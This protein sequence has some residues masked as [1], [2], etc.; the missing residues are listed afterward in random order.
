MK[1]IIEKIQKLKKEKNAIILAHIYQLPEIQDIA[2]FV[3]DSLDLSHKAAKTDADIIVFC[4]VHFMAETAAILSP[5]KKIL[6]PDVQAGCPMADMIN[7][8]Q[9]REFKKDHKNSVTVAYVNT[10]ASLK[11]EC[12]ICCTSSNAVNVVKS[13]PEDKTIIFVPD[14]NLGHY[15]QKMSGREMVIWDGYCP[16]HND[17]MHKEQI[18]KAKE[19]HPEATVLVHPESAP[20][21]IA[22][23]DHA[24]S[25]GQMCKFVLESSNKEFII[26]TEV[27]IIYKLQKENPD[28]KFY[29]V[30]PQ[31]LCQDMK[32]ITLPKVL[33]VLENLSNQVIVPE[34]IRERAYLSIKRMLDIKSS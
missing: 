1:E 29:S 4:G 16:V 28:K 10:T 27:G 15:V 9:L 31:T 12:D 8:E 13:I 2:D 21:I 7:A 33:D 5:Q 22:L 19:A 6:I 20:D 24:M 18:L 23:A 34:D 30:S 26:G 11:T 32:K 14:R 3:G 25:T 17:T